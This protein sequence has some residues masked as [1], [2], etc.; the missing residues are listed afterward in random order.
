MTQVKVMSFFIMIR[1]LNH[2]IQDLFP[3]LC[4]LASESVSLKGDV[5]ENYFDNLL[6]DSIEIRKRVKN[7]F[8]ANSTEPFELLS[9]I[10]RDCVGAVALLPVG[11]KPE[12][13]V[14]IKSTPLDEKQVESVLRSVTT[15]RFFRIR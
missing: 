2:Q 4:P 5:V 11:E 1:G 9:Q 8:S 7:R 6:P 3:F 12:E 15:T 10:G 14:T 13:I